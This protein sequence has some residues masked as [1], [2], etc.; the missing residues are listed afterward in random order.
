VVGLEG[1]KKRAYGL[2]VMF[3]VGG[4]LAHLATP[5]EASGHDEKWMEKAAVSHVGRFAMVPGPDPS[6]SVTYKMD[7]VTYKELAPQGIVCR[8][9]EDGASLFD[10]VLVASQAKDSFHD[11]RVCF[12]AQGWQLDQES[13][14]DVP[15]SRGTFPVTVARIRSENGERWAAFG[16]RTPYGFTGST[17][18]LKLQMFKYSLMHSQSGAGVF[19]R[20]I[21]MSSDITRESLLKFIQSYMN[22]SAK[23]SQGFF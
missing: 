7:P 13:Q 16:Y 8:D 2:A 9:F 1:L 5:A 20:F 23:V 4:L 15:T 3:F 17:N 11:P 18:Q 12:T 10:V 22:A 6:E 21:G 14:A 19:Y